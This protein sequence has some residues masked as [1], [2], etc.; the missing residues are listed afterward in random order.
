MD[1]L[2]MIAI[3]ASAAVLLGTVFM[4]QVQAYPST[5]GW[6]SGTIN[7][8]L[9]R[10]DSRSYRHCHNKGVH[11]L[12]YTS[13][14]GAPETKSPHQRQIERRAAT[15]GYKFDEHRHVRHHRLPCQH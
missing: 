7:P 8:S 12:C 10:I 1:S 11:V 9:T 15:K 5:F 14:P 2:A 13:L 6:E 4:Q 3:G